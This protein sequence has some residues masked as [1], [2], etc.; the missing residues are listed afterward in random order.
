MTDSVPFEGRIELF[1]NGDVAVTT[2][3]VSEFYPRELPFEHDG[4][5]QDD[6]WVAANFTNATEIAAAGGYAAWV[7][8][9]VGEGLLNGLY[10]LTVSLAEDPP[11]ATLL[12]VGVETVA[13]TNAGEY[14]F[15]LEKGIEYPLSVFPRDATNFVYAVTDDVFRRTLAHG[16]V[17]G[18]SHDPAVS[19][20]TIMEDGNRFSEGDCI[21][22]FMYTTN[23]YMNGSYQLEIPVKWYAVNGMVT[24]CLP[25]NVQ[26]VW[27]YSNGTMRIN[28]N[29]I[30]WERQL[31]GLEHQVEE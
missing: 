16:V 13:V 2:N 11:E 26:T 7:D 20:C 12:T 25:D 18:A 30:T 17:A 14:V 27:V 22:S 15:L 4:Y 28:K 19:Y 1:R 10:K 21:A 3:G 23:R 8:D 5:G 24:N 6:E 31:N 9:Q 29:G